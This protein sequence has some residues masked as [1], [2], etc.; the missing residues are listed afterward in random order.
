MDDAL[1]KEPVRNIPRGDVAELSIKCLNL[2]AAD[3][4]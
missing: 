2:K 3:N 1:I 4:R